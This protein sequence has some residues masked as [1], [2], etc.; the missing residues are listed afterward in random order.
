MMVFSVKCDFPRVIRCK[1]SGYF[2][3]FVLLIKGNT[4]TRG[5]LCFQVAACDTLS[6]SLLQVLWF[7]RNQ[8]CAWPMARR[9]H[10][11]G[12]HSARVQGPA[13]NTQQVGSTAWLHCEYRWSCSSDN[14]TQ[15]GKLALQR[16]VPALCHYLLHPAVPSHPC[17]AIHC[18]LH[19]SV[20]FVPMCRVCCYAMY[21]HCHVL[22]PSVAEGH[23]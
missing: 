17:V 12:C 23:K 10:F 5:Y 3:C 19:P 14:S 8:A 11:M 1:M 13:A 15:L 22:P 20:P 21:P 16:S 6:R 9:G 7:V 18:L 4:S 2:P